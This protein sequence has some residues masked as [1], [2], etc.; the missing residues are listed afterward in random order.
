M[1]PLAS[2]FLRF[3]DFFRSNGMK[4]KTGSKGRKDFVGRRKAAEVSSGPHQDL[5]QP[6]IQAKGASEPSWPLDALISMTLKFNTAQSC[7]LC[8]LQPQARG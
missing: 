6:A 5:C 7:H 3:P 1:D 4:D 8:P 2:Y